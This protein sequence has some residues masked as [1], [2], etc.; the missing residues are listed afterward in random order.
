MKEFRL[1]ALIV[2]ILAVNIIIW[3]WQE[4]APPLHNYEYVAMIES[5]LREAT[6]LMPQ[7][8]ARI[9]HIIA[10]GTEVGNTLEATKQELAECQ[11]MR[12]K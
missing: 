5:Q 4:P 8:R 6:A 9:D 7:V 11:M 10:V 12:K 2:V 1:Y 3:T